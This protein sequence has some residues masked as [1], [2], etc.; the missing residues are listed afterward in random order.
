MAATFRVTHRCPNAAMTLNESEP[1]IIQP[2]FS[3]YVI[4]VLCFNLFPFSFKS[5]C[6]CLG[7]FGMIFQKVVLKFKNF[8]RK[9]RL[10]VVLPLVDLE[11]R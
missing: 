3:T 10:Y 11:V 4:H 8:G 2:C 6:L 7:H 9:V 5:L 1:V